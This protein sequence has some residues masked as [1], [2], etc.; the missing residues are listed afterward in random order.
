MRPAQL[1]TTIALYGCLGQG[2]GAQAQEAPFNLAWGPME[3]VVRPSAA[4]REGNIT[5]LVYLADRL[6]TG[7][8]DAE[9]VVLEVCAT[10]GLQRVI[11]V[12][13]IL[14]AAGAE[15]KYAAALAEGTRRYG[16]PEIDPTRESATWHDGRTTLAWRGAG[17]GLR[18]L[19]MTVHGPRFD[20]CSWRH[21][22][23]TGHPAAEH[24]AEDWAT[25]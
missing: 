18:Q 11:W 25:R 24:T 4:R 22:V 14:P 9:E 17:S 21:Q 8:V 10:E 3:E 23:M 20:D 7:L 1:L 6:P 19:T 12:S 15:A 2:T 5:A 16:P 13:H